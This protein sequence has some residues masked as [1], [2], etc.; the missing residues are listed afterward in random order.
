MIDWT[1]IIM[2]LIGLL[3]TIITLVLVPYLNARTKDFKASLTE[4]QLD[5]LDYWVGVGV[6]AVEN[7]FIESGRGPKK[8]EEVKEFIRGFITKNDLDVT[9]EQLDKMIDASV[10]NLI[11][12][13]W[14]QFTGVKGI[15]REIQRVD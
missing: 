8:K 6:Q 4:K 14:E 5:N 13:P 9:P 7:Y 11:N 2:A 15:T 1:E 10:D 12:K 3:G